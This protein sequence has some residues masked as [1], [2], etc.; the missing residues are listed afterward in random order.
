[1]IAKP[2][3]MPAYNEEGNI[4]LVVERVVDIVRDLGLRYKLI[5][6]DV[7]ASMKLG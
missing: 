1:M 7:E 3:V 2:L 6:V 5:V 4:D